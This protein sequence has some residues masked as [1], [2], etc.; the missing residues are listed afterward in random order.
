MPLFTSCN[1]YIESTKKLTDRINRI[2]EIIDALETAMLTIAT[3]PTSL[4][5]TGYLLDT[6]QNKIQ[7]NFRSIDQMA[8][9]IM[10]FNR[11]K[12]YYINQLNGHS[13]RLVDSKN[14]RRR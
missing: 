5:N 3:D 11:I 1:I 9:G 4:G 10:A 12:N 2:Q 7:T 6:G 14:F 13:F 8:D